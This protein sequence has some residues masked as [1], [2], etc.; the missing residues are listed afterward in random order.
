VYKLKTKRRW[1]GRHASFVQEEEEEEGRKIER[2]RE[3]RDG[4]KRKQN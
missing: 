1:S 3:N 4:E 2:R